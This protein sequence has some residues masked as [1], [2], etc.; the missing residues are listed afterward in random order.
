MFALKLKVK[1]VCRIDKT[2]S[3]TFCFIVLNYHFETVF[4]LNFI[5]LSL[6]LYIYLGPPPEPPP[7]PSPEPPPEGRFWQ[8]SP[9]II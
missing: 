9:L 7:E 2:F 1:A 3:K 5:G 4:C 6:V 8:L